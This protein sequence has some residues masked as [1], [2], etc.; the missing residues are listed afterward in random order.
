VGLLHYAPRKRGEA[1]TP[2]CV[3]AEEEDAGLLCCDIGEEKEDSDPP[4]V[5]M[6]G[7]RCCVGVV[8]GRASENAIARAVSAHRCWSAMRS[9][10]CSSERFSPRSSWQVPLSSSL[11]ARDVKKCRDM[12]KAPT[13]RANCRG[14]LTV[15]NK[16]VPYCV[17]GLGWLHKWGYTG[18][19]MVRASGE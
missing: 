11:A 16:F 6:R 2:H 14:S 4:Y 15:G 19:I 1:C 13:W 8:G 9:V 18:F 5:K 12:Q 10:N 17:S 3:L 7:K